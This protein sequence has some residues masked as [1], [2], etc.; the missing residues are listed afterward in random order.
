MARVALRQ[1]GSLGIWVDP[2][3]QWQA[4]PTGKRGRQ[5]VF[6]DAAM[7][8]CLTPR[9]LFGLPLRQTTGLVASLLKLAGLDRS[10]P[11]CST[12]SRR[13]KHLAVQ[14]RCGPGTGALHLL[15]DGTGIKAGATAN[16]APGNMG[17]QSQGKDARF[18]SELTRKR[19]KSGP[20]RSPGRVSA[21]RR[22]CPGCWTRSPLTS[23][24]AR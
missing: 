22:C 8:T 1:Q 21:T 9:S 10:V 15:F 12:L 13:Q 17:L 11:A 6:T 16:G 20:S 18:T 24:S 2:E 5:T 7:Q 14:I 19:W 4:E 3:T 23:P